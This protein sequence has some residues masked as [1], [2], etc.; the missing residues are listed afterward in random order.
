MV[1]WV[2]AQSTPPMQ[3]PYSAGAN[4]SKLIELLDEGHEKVKLSRG[5]LEKIAAW[6]DL[7][8]PYCGDY[9]EANTWTAPEVEK[10]ERYFSKRQQLAAEDQ[11]NITA[12]LQHKS[13]QANGR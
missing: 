5:E 13:S 2:S 1:N 9:T 8:V 10:Y 6:I 7:S 12:W 4:R 11:A 3:P